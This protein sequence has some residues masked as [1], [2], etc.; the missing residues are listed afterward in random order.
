MFSLKP[1]CREHTLTPLNMKYLLSAGLTVYHKEIK[2]VADT[3]PSLMKV[4]V[5]DTCH[6]EDSVYD[7]T[8]V[9]MQLYLQLLTEQKPC[10]STSGTERVTDTGLDYNLQ[11]QRWDDKAHGYFPDSQDSLQQ[12]TESLR[13]SI[14][15]LFLFM[16]Q[17]TSMLMFVWCRGFQT[18]PSAASFL[19]FSIHSLKSSE[20]FSLKIFI[21]SPRM[22]CAES[23]Q[24][25]AAQTTGSKDT[26]LWRRHTSDKHIPLFPSQAKKV[27]SVVLTCPSL[28]GW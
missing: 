11:L 5:S 27:S 8:S 12:L 16:F 1:N 20:C 21:A 7:Q 6:W 13:A 10:R 28:P 15:T 25:E 9:Y 17:S 22:Q 2:S 4:K 23:S 18:R 3:F 26:Q 14:F 24:E 19:L